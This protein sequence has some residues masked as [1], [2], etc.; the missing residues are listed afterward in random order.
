MLLHSLIRQVLEPRA[1]AQGS[2]V[3]ALLVIV[4]PFEYAA[5]ALH[6]HS[7]SMLGVVS[8]MELTPACVGSMYLDVPFSS[9][10]DTC[11][12]ER[13]QSPGLSIAIEPGQG[14]APS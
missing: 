10:A 8:L 5:G 6:K 14:A 1:A 7:D 2:P 11:P 13:P 3:S 4:S 9:C 12:R